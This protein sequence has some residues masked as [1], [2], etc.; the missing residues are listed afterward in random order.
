[1]SS[2]THIDIPF[3]GNCFPAE[4]LQKNSS[5]YY[6]LTAILTVLCIGDKLPVI[7]Y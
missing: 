5:E 2:V 7:I 1:M 3:I 4:K 6:K